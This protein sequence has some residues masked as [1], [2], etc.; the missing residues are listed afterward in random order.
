MNFE[1]IPR[2]ITIATCCIKTQHKP[3]WN[4]TTTGIG[5]EY[6]DNLIIASSQQS[7]IQKAHQTLLSEVDVSSKEQ[8]V[9][10]HTCDVTK[11]N[12]LQTFTD[13][14]IDIVIA[15]IYGTFLPMTSVAVCQSI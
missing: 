4:K 13:G 3:P 5:I 10:A 11:Q 7:S 14:R 9:E 12:E 6:G 2:R 15:T 8:V 1:A